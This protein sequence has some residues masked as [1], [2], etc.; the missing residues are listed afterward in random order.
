MHCHTR[1]S[2]QAKHLK[3]LRC[4]DC[5]SRPLDVYRTAKRRGMDLVTITDHDS[6]DGCLELLDRLGPVPDFVMGEEATAFFPRFGHEVHVGIY[7]LTEAQHRE[8]QRL[9]REGDAL[10]AYLRA[11]G[12]S[13]P[14]II[15]SMAFRIRRASRNLSSTWRG[16]LTSSKSATA[17]SSSSTIP[18][19]CACSKSAR[20]V[21]L[22]LTALSR[23]R[24]SAARS[25][26]SREAT[27]IHCV[28]SGAPILRARPQTPRSSSPTS[29]AAAAA[30][31]A[32]TRTTFRLPRTSTAWCF[33]ITQLYFR[34]ATANFPSG[35]GSR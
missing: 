23:S 13:T 21:R 27:P 8:I 16:F 12:L 3:F 22:S 1:H 11:Q 29:A 9:R 4:R 35:R 34:L 20:A 5:Y 24:R 33:G 2:G 6:I 7:G 19:S 14:S 28:A 18:S 10:V 25:G 30:F 15:F 26:G 17:R 32:L 31:S